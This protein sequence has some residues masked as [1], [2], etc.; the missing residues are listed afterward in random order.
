MDYVNPDHRD[1]IE[2]MI[3]VSSLEA[4]LRALV[5]ICDEKAEHIRANWQDVETARTWERCANK[6][7]VA[8]EEAKDERV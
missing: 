2:R 7:L 4:I 8:A 5:E 6:I 3:D 1:A